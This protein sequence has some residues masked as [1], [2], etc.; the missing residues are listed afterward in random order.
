MPTAATQVRVCA[1]VV[2]R[3]RL[4]FLDR[5]LTLWIWKPSSDDKHEREKGLDHSAE[6]QSPSV[7]RV[8]VQ[9]THQ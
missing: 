7:L 1:P 6:D 4:S 8:P 9:M 3:K 5:F 2:E